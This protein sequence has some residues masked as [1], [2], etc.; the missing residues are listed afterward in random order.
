MTA[1]GIG[2]AAADRADDRRTQRVDDAPR[3]CWRTG[4]AEEPGGPDP[5]RTLC[6]QAVMAAGTHKVQAA[7][8]ATGP[9]R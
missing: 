5:A 3:R 8:Q 9:G 7:G 1:E 4:C 6:K 2:A